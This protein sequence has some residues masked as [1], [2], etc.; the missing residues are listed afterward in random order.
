V[1]TGPGSNEDDVVVRVDE[2][3]DG[4]SAFEVDAPDAVRLSDIVSHRGEA[5]ALDQSLR[6]DAIVR[7]HRM[8]FGVDQKEILGPRPRLAAQPCAAP[9]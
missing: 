6:D 4:G 1:P 2:A 7:I 3:W 9:T 5:A 8:D